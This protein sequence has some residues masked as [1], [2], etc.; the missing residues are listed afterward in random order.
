MRRGQQY[1]FQMTKL[2]L[3][4]W[5]FFAKQHLI[6]IRIPI[7]F[8]SNSPLFSVSWFSISV[9]LFRGDTLPLL[10][11]GLS[12]PRTTNAPR[13]LKEGLH[14]LQVLSGV[15]KFFTPL[16]GLNERIHSPSRLSSSSIH[17]LCHACVSKLNVVPA[18]QFFFYSSLAHG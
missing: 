13:S 7:Y 6:L 3:S 1:F 15:W 12:P 10:S 14:V 9:N 8:E 4:I 18:L 17:Q 11:A 16:P 2:N 5:I